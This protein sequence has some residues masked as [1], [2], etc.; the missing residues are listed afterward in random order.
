MRLRQIA[1]AAH[2]LDAVVADLR[3]VLGLPAGFADP[4]VAI[5]GLRNAVLPLGDTFLEVVSPVEAETAAGR[6]LARRGGD[7]GYMGMVQGEDTDA[8]RQRAAAL[9]VRVVWHADL[10]DIRGTHLHPRDLGGPLLSFDTP[11]PPAAWRWA[12]PDWQRAPGSPIARALAGV[13]MQCADP[14]RTAERWAALF[15][16]S[17]L[18]RGGGYEI[19]LDAATLRFLPGAAPGSDA[20]VQVDVACRDR[21]AALAAAAARGLPIAGDTVTVCGTALRLR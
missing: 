8:C 20:V 15:D 13:G 6:Y 3:A 19:G 12:G 2:D 21:A 16:R 9:G 18:A 11:T 14:R 5:F 7:C 4:G 10:D 1:F 17:A